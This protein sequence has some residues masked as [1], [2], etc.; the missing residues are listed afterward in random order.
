MKRFLLFTMLCIVGV[1]GMRAQTWTASDLEAGKYVFL[2]VGS[3]RYLG[4]ANEWG[5]QTSLIECSHY[6]TLAKVSDGVYTIESQVSNGGTNYYF[7]GSFMDG[8]ATNVNIQDDG[9]G[10]FIMFSNEGEYYG[11]DGS[12]TVLAKLTDNTSDNAHWKILPYDEVYAD[13]S[14]DNPVDVTYMIL[15]SNFDRNNRNSE[16]WTMDASNKNLSGGDDTNRCAESWR[17]SFTLSQT[18]TVPNGYY[19]LRCQ[20]AL[21]E[22]TVTGNNFPVVYLNDA[23]KPFK[24]MTDEETSMS[25]MSGKFTEGKYWT[26]WTDVVTVSGKSI[27]LGVKGTRTDTWCVWDNFQLMYLGPIDLTEYANSLAEA[28]AKA[29]ATEGTIPTAAYNAINAVVLENNKTYEDEE[30]YSDAIQAINNAV[31]TYASAEIVAA[32]SRY[33]SVKNAV[34]AISNTIDTSEADALA[35]DGTDADLND[36]VESLRETFQAELPNLT[37][38][39]DPGYIDV[40]NVMVDNASVSVNTDYWTIDNLSESGGSAGF[41]GYDECEFYN[42]NFKF[43]QTIAI[44][45]GTWEFGVTGFHRAGDHSTYFYAGSD[46]KVLIPGV[47]ASVVNSMAAAKE[48]FDAGNGKLSLKFLI[49]EAQDIEIGIDNQDAQTDKWTIFRNFT[50]KYYGPVDYSVYENQWSEAVAAA[51]EAMTTYAEYDNFVSTEKS[52]L[53]TAKADEP[54]AAG[55]KAGYIEKIS[56]L[57]DATAAYIAA[58]KNFE[59]A[60][61]AIAKANEIKNN[62]NFASASAITTFADAIAAIQSK[63]DE[64]T[65]TTEEATDAGTTLG[66]VVTGWHAGANSA[67]SNYLEDGF[68]LNDFGAALY[69][70]TWSV[71]GDNDGSE[72]SVPFYEYWTGDGNS[73][74]ENTWTGT[75][76]DLPNGLYKVSA[77]VRVRA[78]NETA[79]ADAT[80]ITMDVNG[81]TAVDVTEG[82]QIGETQF[83]LATYEAEGLVKDGTLKL[84]FNVAADNNI[85]WLCF[86][87]VKYE[88][89]RDLNPEELAVLPTSITLTDVALT[90]TENSKQVE[91]TYVPE[92]ASEGYLTWSSSDPTVVIVSAEGVVTGV[93]SGTATIT[94]TSTLNSEVSGTCTVTVTYPE[95]VLPTSYYVND[96][97]KRTVYTLGEN[98]IKNGSFEYPNPV[99]GWKATN[100]TTDAVVSNFTINE[101]GGYKD[102]HYITTNAG[103]AGAATSIRMAIPVEAG[104]TYY[105]AVATSGKAPASNNFQYNALFKLKSDYAEDGVLKQFEWPQG[106]DKTSTEWSVTEYVFTADADHPYVGVRMSWNSSTNFDNFILAEVTSTTE[107]GNVDYATAAIPTANIGTGA[108]QYSQEAVDAANALVQGTATVEEVLA[109]YDALTTL[110]APAEGQLFNIILTYSGW[111]Y[112]NKA[113]TY[114]ANGRTDGG[115]YNIQYKEGANVNL[116]QAFTF[117]KVEGNKYKMSQ[118]DADG[119]ARYISTGVPYSGNTAQIRT[120]TNADDALAVEIIP[121]TTEGVW[122]LKNTE[123]NQYIGSQDAGVYTVNSH[124]DFKLVETTKPSIT[125]NTT[126]AG[127]GTTM[128]PFA[129]SEIPEGVTVYSCSE[130]NGQELTLTEVEEMEANKP[131]IIEGAWNE[132]L[133]GD[134]QGTALTYTDGLL[135]GVYTTTAAPAGSYVLQKQGEKV[136][137]FKVEEGTTMNV[138]ANRAY[139]TAPAGS[140]VKAIF[141]GGD[142][143]GINGIN[144]AS[145]FGNATIYNL[146]GQRVSNPTKGIYIVNGKKVMI[147]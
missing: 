12:S 130:L 25:T 116:A 73:L 86:Q 99:Y 7:T 55:L 83:Q 78:K 140:E 104:K 117:T 139:L 97:A 129:V 31:A 18:I 11:Y 66:T 67:A 143:T 147:K 32:Y 80:G 107:V 71:E 95:S 43:Y 40:T 53:Q 121:T 132:T 87:H 113:M 74:G 34:L 105:F 56:A 6:N 44:T 141:F 103:S 91:V 89:V 60:K 51:E 62:H 126:A 70:N 2:N 21:T 88:F 46:D 128:L 96:G 61:K 65:L 94:A 13:A 82:T 39:E 118:I 142:A 120:T 58:S 1:L 5:T 100:Y 50:L 24:S 112:D 131:Y 146:S 38:P 81:G 110:N 127:Y 28:V 136:G 16:A 8:A 36:A 41:C 63:Y 26:D 68:G 15:C 119:V 33:T 54:T 79:T 35:N 23:T 42:R 14:E 30:G 115:L 109:A 20:A 75:L 125:I 138:G 92:D 145:D 123:A 137:F 98:L 122:N 19:K 49:E 93:T 4:P 48:Y 111:T 52:A 76:T 106:A 77:W 3:G 29:Q 27:T 90:A 9:N 135:T 108:F 22:Y 57:T 72:F 144:A 64:G 101:T 114:I 124:I 134:A 45:T 85:S 47:E 10:S 133:T 84:N 59:A 69:V 17:S 102:D 37:I